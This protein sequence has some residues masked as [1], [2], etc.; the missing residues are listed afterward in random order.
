M[1]QGCPLSPYLFVISAEILSLYIKEKSLIEG[2]LYNNH[3][4]I[5]SQFADD[6]SLAV[7]GTE[8]NVKNCFSVLS[9]FEEVS[10]LK[11]NVNKTEALMLGTLNK[12]LCKNL[13]IN[14]VEKSTRVLG[15][16][17]T[18]DPKSLI[19]I[20]YDGLIER[21]AAR[22][23][24]WKRRNLSLLG[25]INII[26]CLGISQVI[27]LFSTLGS[28][29]TEYLKSLEQLLFSFIWGKGNDRIKRDTLIGPCDMGGL[30]MVN[31]QILKQSI[32]VSWIKRLI[33]D[34][35][36]WSCYVT[37]RL[38]NY[39]EINE[40]NLK[41][42]FRGNLNKKDIHDWFN[43]KTSNPWW[44]ILHDWGEYNYTHSVMIQNREYI[45]S[46]TLWFNSNL[47]IANST[48]F[49]RTWFEAGIKYIRD[50]VNDH[51]WKSIDELEKEYK[52]KPKILEYLG[53]LHCIN[54]NW[55]RSIMQPEQ[56]V[57]IE[58]NPYKIDV[59]CKSDKCSKHVCAELSNLKCEPPSNRWERWVEDLDTEINEMDWLDSLPEIMNCTISTRL[60]SFSYRFAMRDVYT[61]TKLYKIGKSSTK[62]CYLCK[63]CNETIAHLYWECP[64]TKRLWERLKIHIRHKI[65]VNITLDK[66]VMLLGMNPEDVEDKV[67]RVLQLLCLVVKSF[68]HSSKCKDIYPSEKG[69]MKAI[70]RIRNIEECIAFKRGPNATRKF[71]NKWCD[72]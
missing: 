54:K 6:T 61:N 52:I 20:N 58:A 1:R 27:F 23:Q 2:I 62:T 25:R 63:A 46:Q 16:H 34:H 55:R 30:N 51:K 43:I 42:F 71:K 12:S 36:T 9:D 29:G 70:D 50:L 11:V 48:V 4:F 49:Y 66:C 32:N 18:K 44:E 41:Y 26:K 47:K 53:I 28:P 69:L 35:D 8:E 13:K 38:R 59:L 72:L 14:W 65:G 24:N 5:V 3:N 15:I 56:L 60:K 68:I 19:D 10:G 57:I 7:K 64:H 21:I 17:I 31:V 45:L 37:S 22:L 33:M 39:F 67:P 40:E